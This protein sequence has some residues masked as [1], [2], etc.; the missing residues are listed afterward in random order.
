M[1]NSFQVCAQ[2]G[3][4]VVDAAQHRAWHASLVRAHAE[5]SDTRDPLEYLAEQLPEADDDLPG[6][7]ARERT[8]GPGAPSGG[9]S[10][11]G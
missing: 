4:A 7:C 8:G 5:A 11:V 2:C 3:S 1:E 10:H 6:L 9:E